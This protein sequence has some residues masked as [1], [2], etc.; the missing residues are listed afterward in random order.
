MQLFARLDRL[1]SMIDFFED[2]AVKRMALL[3]KKLRNERRIS[4][5]QLADQAGVNPSV[6]HRAER[7][8]DAKLSTW[9]KLFEGLG[10]Y[11][12]FDAMESSE[13]AA[14]LLEEEAEARRERRRGY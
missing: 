10:Y 14:D 1:M 12:E 11:L 9:D 6:V 4:Q 13:E 8:G 7:G 5:L 3:L 2:S